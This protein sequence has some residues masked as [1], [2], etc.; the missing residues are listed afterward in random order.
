MDASSKQGLGWG[1]TRLSRYD[2]RA[3]GALPP[4]ITV[5]ARLHFWGDWI[6]NV[7][8]KRINSKIYIYAL[9]IFNEGRK[10][11]IYLTTHSTHFIYDY[12]ASDIW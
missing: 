11:I 3:E 7:S 10:E 1:K 6:C 5:I 9:L 4:S 8:L 2:I 12:M